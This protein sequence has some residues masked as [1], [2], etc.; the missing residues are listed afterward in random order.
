M[1]ARKRFDDPSIWDYESVRPYLKEWRRVGGAARSFTKLEPADRIGC[2]K[3]TLSG[4]FAED[5]KKFAPIRSYV[6]R[7]V[8]V[9]GLNDEEAAYF[10]CLVMA[11]EGLFEAERLQALQEAQRIRFHH[12]QKPIEGEDHALFEDWYYFAI[13]SILAGPGARYDAIWLGRHLQPQVAP[14]DVQKA[15][16][17]LL[18]RGFLL[19]LPGGGVEV[20]KKQLSIRAEHM[21][22]EAYGAAMRR[23]HAWFIERA[24]TAMRDTPALEREFSALSFRV[25]DRRLPEVIQVLRRLTEEAEFVGESGEP[26]PGRC[27][28]LTVHLFPLS[29]PVGETD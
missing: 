15:L 22:G 13:L 29:R 10:R 17:R 5:R 25:P 27:Y 7:F 9:I 26:E 20:V 21:Q 28:A 11:E 2:G 23:W 3:A 12:W 6:E 1:A 18:D 14:E 4:I 19:S 16:N 24:P 8:G